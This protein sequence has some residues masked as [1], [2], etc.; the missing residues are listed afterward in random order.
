MA[1]DKMLALVIAVLLIVAP[2]YVYPFLLMK[3][4]CM[5][6]MAAS[7]NLLFGYGGMLSFGHAA[8]IGSSAYVTA[9]AAKVLALSPLVAVLLGVLTAAAI[10]L[11]FGF[12]AIR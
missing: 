6:L 7:F 1:I 3:M 2:L 4:M 10:G 12:I 11:V 9:Y 8:F 5:A